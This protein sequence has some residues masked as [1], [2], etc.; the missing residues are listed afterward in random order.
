M[1]NEAIISEELQ[2]YYEDKMR[3]TRG[4]PQKE[5]PINEVYAVLFMQHMFLN[6]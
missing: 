3:K 2:K 6:N 5:V 4:E 1:E